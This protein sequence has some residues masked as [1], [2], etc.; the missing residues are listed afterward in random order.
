MTPLELEHFKNLLADRVNAITDWL[1]SP[2]FRDDDDVQKVYSLLAQIKDAIT[3]IENNTYGKCELCDGIIE[4]DRLEIQPAA[5]VCLECISDEEKRLLEEEL[6]LA[7]KIHRALLPQ[8]VAKIDGFEVVVKSIAARMVGG[9]YYDF[10]PARSG[11]MGRIVIA[12]VMGKGLPAGLLM[13]N[14]QGALRVLAE[15]FESPRL[16]IARLNKWFCRN[17]AVTKFVSMACIAV[18][19]LSS[20]RAELIYTNAGHCP[21]ILIRRDGAAELLEPTGGV[22]G[23]HEAFTYDERRFEISTGDTILLY[24]DGV[25]EAENNQEQ[26][27]GEERLNSLICGLR[28]SVIESIPENIL[29]EVKRFSGKPELSDDC[30]IIALRKL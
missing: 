3:R 11:G 5:K 28:S 2:G 27:F 12:D 26:Q 29:K 7:S 22:L 23:V 17:V 25:T 15:D 20:D 18:R 6:F 10:L 21:P 19:P 1:E 9:D 30:T 24:T 13:S 14:V 8:K 4:P 16:L